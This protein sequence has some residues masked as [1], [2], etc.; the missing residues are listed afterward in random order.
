MQVSESALSSYYLRYSNEIIGFLQRVH[1]DVN[2]PYVHFHFSSH[3]NGAVFHKSGFCDANALMSFVVTQKIRSIN[4]RHSLETSNK[5]CTFV[6]DI[7]CHDIP[8]FENKTCCQ[9][10]KN[11]CVECFWHIVLPHCMRILDYLKEKTNEENTTVV[12]S[13]S[14]GIHIWCHS[15]HMINMGMEQRK[16]LVCDLK[17]KQLNIDEH[18][19]ISPTRSIKIPLSIHPTAA[20]ASVKFDPFSIKKKD[21]VFSLFLLCENI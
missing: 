3:G 12:F 18:V 21:D 16:Q 8:L 10:Q 19:L 13:G 15:E 9:C 4:M 7:D 20:K 1:S 17:S 2:F 5:F 11:L 6:I 14:K